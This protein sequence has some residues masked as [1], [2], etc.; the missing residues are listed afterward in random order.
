M[1]C[2]IILKCLFTSCCLESNHTCAVSLKYHN[3]K[4]RY[5]QKKMGMH[6]SVQSNV[7]KTYPSLELETQQLN[8]LSRNNILLMWANLDRCLHL[9]MTCH[10]YVKWTNLC[11]KTVKIKLQIKSKNLDFVYFWIKL[12]FKLILTVT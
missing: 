5:R 8:I 11:H 12:P 6:I 7:K 1:G 4:N 2:D 9:L 3:V 10:H